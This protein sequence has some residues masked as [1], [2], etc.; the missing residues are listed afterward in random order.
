MAS[1][2]A[3]YP[4]FALTQ[5]LWRAI[6]RLSA[7][8]LYK[9]ERYTRFR[10]RALGARGQVKDWED[11]LHDAVIS[12]ASGSR[13]WPQEIDLF[14]MLKGAIRS[15]TDRRSHCYLPQISVGED[16]KGEPILSSSIH[17]ERI[18]SARE[19]VERLY[20]LFAHDSHALTLLDGWAMGL[21]GPEIRAAYQLSDQTFNAAV[22]RI[23]RRL[24]VEAFDGNR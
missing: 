13:Q 3:D 4:E 5:R 12:I 21:T 14:V 24:D 2:S 11:I 22:K 17:P 1:P 19:E 23:L 8:Q 18:Y 10:L 9:L 6:E 20:S 15:L 7:T 16:S